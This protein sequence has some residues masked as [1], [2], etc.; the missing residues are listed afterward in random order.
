MAAD[1][2]CR[3]DSPSGVGV[4]T[5]TVMWERVCVGAPPDALGSGMTVSSWGSGPMQKGLNPAGWLHQV[6]SGSLQDVEPAGCVSEHA[7]LLQGRPLLTR[8][9][10]QWVWS[11][12]VDCGLSGVCFR[13][14]STRVGTG[15]WAGQGWT[16]GLLPPLL[17]FTDGLGMDH[18]Y[19]L[20]GRLA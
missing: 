19:R 9:V 2:N 3:R 10:G 5:R 4:R 1:A 6:P 13:P 15:P 7:D 18:R 16:W 11:M 14:A 8:V 17:E 12:E 20:E